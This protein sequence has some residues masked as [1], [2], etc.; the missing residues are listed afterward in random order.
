MP[1]NLRCDSKQNDLQLAIQIDSSGLLSC[2]GEYSAALGS[3]RQYSLSPCILLSVSQ[4]LLK[5]VKTCRYGMLNLYI[6][7]RKRAPVIKY[8]YS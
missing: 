1:R 4:K 2:P 7:T 6:F 8:D 5:L 3:Q